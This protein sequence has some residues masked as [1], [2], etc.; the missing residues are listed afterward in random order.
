MTNEQKDMVE[1][2]RSA[3]YSYTEMARLLDISVNTIQSFCR[4]KK[5]TPVKRNSKNPDQERL[6]VCKSCGKLLPPAGKGQP[7]RYCSDECRRRWWKENPAQLERKAYSVHVCSACGEEFT[8][9]GN[10]NRKFC[11]HA[12]YISHRF[13]RRDSDDDNNPVSG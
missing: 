12:C 1:S 6:K 10:Q 5:I 7:K 11:S 2:L 13:K 3:G 9:Y 8:S 4:R